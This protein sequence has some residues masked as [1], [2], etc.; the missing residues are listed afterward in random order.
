M[1]NEFKEVWHTRK[2]QGELPTNVTGVV[3]RLDHFSFPWGIVIYTTGDKRRRVDCK[4]CHASGS[5]FAFDTLFKCD[6][7]K[8]T[9]KQWE[10]LKCQ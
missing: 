6:V 2:G 7:C 8:G 1:V 9:G 5:V 10:Y 4:R 3:F